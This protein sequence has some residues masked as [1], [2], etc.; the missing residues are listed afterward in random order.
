[1]RRFNDFAIPVLNPACFLGGIL[2]ET[3]MDSI[4]Y[5]HLNQ[6]ISFKITVEDIFTG[7]C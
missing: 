2:Q 7:I 4:G 3:G 6:I 1:M 5:I